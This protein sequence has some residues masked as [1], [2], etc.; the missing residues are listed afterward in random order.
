M[1]EL[2]RRYRSLLVIAALL[3]LPLFFL[4]GSA[5]GRESSG[6]LTRLVHWVTGPIQA[7]VTGTWRAVARTGDA[8]LW[9]VGVADENVELR[10][11]L[12]RMQRERAVLDEAGRENRRLRRL[13]D[14]ERSL[15]G[16]RSVV[17]RVIG[18]GESPNYRNVRI[19]RGTR[20]GVQ[21]RAGVVTADGVVGRVVVASREYADVLLLVDA[22]MRL[23][24]MAERSRTRGVLRGAAGRCRL[25]AVDRTLELFVDDVLVT[26]GLDGTFPKGIPVGRVAEVTRPRMGLY[27]DALVEPR[28]VFSRLEEVIVLITSP[29]EV[30]WPEL[31][32]T[33]GNPGVADDAGG[34]DATAPDVV[35]VGRPRP[36]PAEAPGAATRPAVRAP[37]PAVAPASAPAIPPADSGRPRVDP[38]LSPTTPHRRD[39]GTPTSRPPTTASR[40][41]GRAEDRR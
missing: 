2:L 4:Y 37:V 14:L 38:A 25:D 34:M 35:S 33:R 16:T 24:V 20:D 10:Q 32:G 7:A 39:T 36:T 41:A 27:L 22:G 17:A 3:L 15:P 11:Q 8:Y 9:L 19:D 12:Q 40:D 13:L 30:T 1:R 23:D 6:R 5:S 18:F 26:S 28:V 31:G 29:D 21:R